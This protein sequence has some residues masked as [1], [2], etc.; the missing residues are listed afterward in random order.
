MASKKR[1][2]GVESLEEQALVLTNLNRHPWNDVPLQALPGHYANEPDTRRPAY[3][4][5]TLSF[6]PSGHKFVFKPGD[7]VDEILPAD[8]LANLIRAGEATYDKAV[9]ETGGS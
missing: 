6:N 2:N 8:V 4:V 5:A 7:R 3:A 9:A 1:T